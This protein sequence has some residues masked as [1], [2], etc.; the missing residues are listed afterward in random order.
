M[1]IKTS[2]IPSDWKMMTLGQVGVTVTGK[3]P[4]KDNPE[5]W[6]DLLSFIT[7][8]D[9]I[10]DSKHLKTVAR[11][12]SGSG[13]NTLKKMIIP[14]GSVV[15]TCIG[16]DMGKVVINS[17]DSVTNQQINSIK[18]NDNNNKDF[19]YYLLK[20]SYSILRNHAIGG[21][22]M[23]ILNK[24]TFESLEFIFPSLTEQQAIAAALS[25]LDDKIELLRTQN[26]TLENITQTIFKHWFVDFEFPG[27]DGNPYKSS[28]G[29][30][31]ESALGKI[32]NNWRIGKYEDVVDVVT[33]KG[34]KKDNLR[35]NGLYKVLGANGEIG[36]T[37]EYLFDEDL[38]LT[39]RVGTLGTIFI[40][41]GK[42]WISDNVLISKPKS[43][44]NCYFAY[45]QLRKLNLESLNRGSTQPLITQTDLK[46]VE[47]ILP[48]KEIL[49]DWHC[50]A[51]SLFT[52]IFNN[53]FQ[54]NTLSKIR[55]TLLPKL[56][57]GEIRVASFNN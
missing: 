4:S 6:G 29:K 18:V 35:S 17:Y 8:T 52:K 42:V 31:I 56:M 36:K 53:D 41:R 45:F 14:A 26:K 48:P 54:I 13:I 1:E 49:F 11:K 25:S 38:I 34:M 40:S 30:M 10:S 43:D 24:S 32:P 50:M 20:N 23:P 21:S 57:K 19:V 27:K 33:G 7:P 46:N 47:I 15:V 2:A 39:G 22:T 37:D 12:L 9:I 5:D 28:G 44:E 16:S 51:S 3:T 55:D